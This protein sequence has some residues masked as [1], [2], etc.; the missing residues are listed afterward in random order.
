MITPKIPPSL[1]KQTNTIY[2]TFISINLKIKKKKPNITL[3]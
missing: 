2:Q 1:S 3:K